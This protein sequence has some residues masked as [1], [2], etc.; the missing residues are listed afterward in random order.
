MSGVYGIAART[1]IANPA[2]ILR[3]MFE[4]RRSDAPATTHD[5][6][7]PNGCVALGGFSLARF[8]SVG[9]FA[10][11]TDAGVC[12]FVDGSVY[13]N[14]TAGRHQSMEENGAQV[15]LQAYLRSGP[16][17]LL[18]VGGNFNVVW[19]DH[20]R[21]SLTVAN[22][23]LGQRPLFYSQPG[24]TFIFAS[25]L[26]MVLATDVVPRNID[27]HGFAD[28]LTYMYTLGSRTL[29]EDVHL[30]PPATVLTF[31]AHGL[32]AKRY[33]RVDQIEPYGGYGDCR[34]EELDDTF[35]RVVTRA[36]RA[37]LRTAVGLTG[38][39]DSRCILAAAVAEN[40]DPL[41]FTDGQCDS[42]DVILAQKV[43]ATTQVEH[44][45]VSTDTERLAEWL[46]P[47]V[48][49]LGA[50][51]GT[52][53]SHPLQHIYNTPPFDALVLGNGANLIRSSAWTAPADLPRTRL[54]TDLA[55]SRM[56]TAHSKFL[57]QL[58]RPEYRSIG[59]H[60]PE[61]RLRHLLDEYQPA[62]HP[63][64]ALKYITLEESQRKF[65][66]K[67]PW[68]TLANRDVTL[69]YLDYQWIE[70]VFSIPIEDR[71]T[72]R[73]QVDMLERLH[74]AVLEIPHEK[75]ML[76]LSLSPGWRKLT[77]YYRRAKRYI[78]YRLGRSN[79]T[80]L[81]VKNHNYTELSRHEMRSTLMDILYHPNATF[82]AYLQW[83][84]VRTLLDQHFLGIK[85]WESLT[86]TLTVFEIAHHLWI[87]SKPYIDV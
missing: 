16:D 38:G 39:I 8:D 47:M 41:A 37:G 63:I 66:N 52:L 70:A 31:D 2:G 28:L 64:S 65:L 59:V 44:L 82:R 30:L 4:A 85:S 73:I 36:F 80:P 5:W 21:N 14:A 45:V 86:A 10:E 35:R 57:G 50:T 34:L 48:Y 53:H 78:D 6:T 11:D 69:P 79:N 40:L 75:T 77:R 51:T 76:P 56:S 49:H 87:E 9:D 68:I 33:W 62:D 27:V 23:R 84:V 46:V 54:P 1:P 71:L 18:D 83:P 74:P 12:C 72:N 29:M 26:A 3:T 20:T 43:A 25:M 13:L 81:K 55:Y 60:A 22:D 15:L 58:W 32:R 67:G 24:D 61:D 42:S 19:W 17:C 7:S